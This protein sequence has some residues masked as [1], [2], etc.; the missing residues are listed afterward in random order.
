MSESPSKKFMYVQMRMVAAIAKIGG[1]DIRS[2]QVQTMVYMCLVGMAVA[3]VAKDVGIRVGEKTLE[4]AIKKIPGSALTKINQKI[5]FRF[6]TKFG[7]KGVINL[8]KMIPLAGG[9]I[10]GRVDVASTSVIAKNAM[11]MFING[12]DLDDSV[13]DE[14]EIV[15]LEA[16]GAVEDGPLV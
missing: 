16:I 1:Y 2:D 8:G 15:E 6:I 3:D 12:E 4:A 7:E 13:P 11:K 5:G 14:D 10:G 9:V